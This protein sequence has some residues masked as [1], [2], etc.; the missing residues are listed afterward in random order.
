MHSLFTIQYYYMFAYEK[1][2]AIISNKTDL[3]NYY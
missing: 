3:Y 2:N 1:V